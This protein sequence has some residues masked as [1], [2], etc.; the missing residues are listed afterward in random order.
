MTLRSIRLPHAS[1][2]FVIPQ[3]KINAKIINMLVILRR[4]TYEDLDDLLCAVNVIKDLID[5]ELS[6]KETVDKLFT[7]L[8]EPENKDL[9]D[10]YA[11]IYNPNEVISDLTNK[12]DAIIALTILLSDYDDILTSDDRDEIINDYADEEYLVQYDEK[13]NQWVPQLEFGYTFMVSA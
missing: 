1:K 13:A 7:S 10:I 8:L 2:S 11:D 9:A 12:E 4:T 5:E 3:D 6:E